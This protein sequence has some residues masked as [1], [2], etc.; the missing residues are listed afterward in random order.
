MRA[1]AESQAR[2]ANELRLDIA[3]VRVQCCVICRHRAFIDDIRFLVSNF[4][5]IVVVRVSVKP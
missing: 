4:R 3:R 5:K 1:L 2:D